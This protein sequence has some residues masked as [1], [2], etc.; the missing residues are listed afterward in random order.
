MPLYFKVQQNTLLGG[1]C[2]QTV[3][4]CAYFVAAISTAQ[5]KQNMQTAGSGI[6]LLHMS[7]A[8]PSSLSASLISWLGQGV[9]AN[10]HCL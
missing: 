8:E 3:T 2:G 9:Y 5:F 10:L 7:A 1:D 6:Q 4:I